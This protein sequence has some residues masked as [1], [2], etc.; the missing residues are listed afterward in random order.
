MMKI[1]ILDEGRDQREYSAT[2][3]SAMYA[4]ENDKTRKLVISALGVETP[5]L[6]KRS[7]EE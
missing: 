4:D 6:K 7:T 3:R 2:C 5:D 1:G